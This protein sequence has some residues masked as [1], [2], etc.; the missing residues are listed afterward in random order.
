[1]FLKFVNTILD[2]L[3]KLLAVHEPLEVHLK[4]SLAMAGT[5]KIKL[6]LGLHKALINISHKIAYCR[7]FIWIGLLVSSCGC[8]AALLVN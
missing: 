5:I 8:G 4:D 1:M 3:D 2:T 6:Y 7:A